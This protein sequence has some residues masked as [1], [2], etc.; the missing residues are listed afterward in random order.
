MTASTG[1]SAS[2]PEDV[3]RLPV[4][5][6]AEP[7][8]R[9]VRPKCVNDASRQPKRTVTPGVH[10]AAAFSSGSSVYCEMR[11]Y[12]SRGEGVPDAPAEDDVDE[13][14]VLRNWQA[15]KRGKGEAGG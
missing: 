3:R 11:W 12:A 1:A 6:S 4:P 13:A 2:T 7:S 8:A 10:S 9:A 14:E 15:Y 5:S